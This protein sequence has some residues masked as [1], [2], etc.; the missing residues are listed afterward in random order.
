MS[1]KATHKDI[2]NAALIGQIVAEAELSDVGTICIVDED[3]CCG[4]F[5]KE[6]CIAEAI[7]ASEAAVW[8]WLNASNA[9]ATPL[10]ERAAEIADAKEQRNK[11]RIER[12]YAWVD[13]VCGVIADLGE[14]E[15]HAAALLREGNV[16]PG[17]RIVKVWPRPK[18]K[19]ARRA[20]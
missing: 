15:L 6:H 4:H 20:R 5:L 17:W 13:A 11:R 1:Q 7:G 12:L 18:L 2:R 14:A 8:L 19:L 10:D 9:I 3:D 16:P